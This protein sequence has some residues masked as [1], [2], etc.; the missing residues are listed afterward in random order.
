VHTDPEHPSEANRARITIARTAP[1]DIQQRQVIVSVDDGPKATL[2]FGETTSWDIEAGPHV[3]KANN[4][5]V[6]KKLR[7]QAAPGEHVE[8]VIANRASR[9]MLGFLALIGVAPLYLTIERASG[10][11]GGQT[12]V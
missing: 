3:L 9:L 11:D 4:T 10:S 8:F 7:F 2:L 5:L 6:W 1:T 12:G